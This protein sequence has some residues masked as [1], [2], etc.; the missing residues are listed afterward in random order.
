[1]AE[2]AGN[3]ASRA[4]AVPEKP[5]ARAGGEPPKAS[6]RGASGKVESSRLALGDTQAIEPGA[7]AGTAELALKRLVVTNGIE[8][9]EPA[10]ISGDLKANDEPVYAF[11]ELVND[12]DGDGSVVITFEHDS[13]KSVGHIPL[14]IPAK[15]DRWRT[16]GR[17]RHIDRDGQWAAVVR[18][19]DGRELGRRTFSVGS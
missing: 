2:A 13:G 12:G 14:S 3:G 4:G 18:T 9:R 10:A 17:T 7:S 11:V 1:S 19:A 8:G 15:R 5:S 6:G 16:W